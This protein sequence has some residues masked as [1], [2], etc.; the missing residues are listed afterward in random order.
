MGKILSLVSKACKKILRYNEL[1]S[2]N[3]ALKSQGL[4][5]WGW[6]NGHYYSPVHSLED[7]GSYEDVVTKS[8]EEFTKSIPDFSDEELDKTIKEIDIKIKIIK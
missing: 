1:V 7:L 2:E 4:T 3:E 5:A 8:R 6:P